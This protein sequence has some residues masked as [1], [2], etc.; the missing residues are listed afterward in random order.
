VKALRFIDLQE[1]LACLSLSINAEFYPD[2]GLG[3]F[4]VSSLQ[5]IIRPL[6]DANSECFK[7][8]PELPHPEMYAVYFESLEAAF[9]PAGAERFTIWLEDIWQNRQRLQWDK[10]EIALA[11]WRGQLLHHSRDLLGLGPLS[12]PL[13]ERL[14]WTHADDVE[15]KIA[16]LEQRAPENVWDRK[17]YRVRRFLQ[18]PEIVDS[19]NNIADLEIAHHPFRPVLRACQNYRFEIFWENFKRLAPADVKTRLHGLVVAEWSESIAP[20]SIAPDDLSSR[21]AAALSKWSF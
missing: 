17:M 13:V 7:E 6:I 2:M 8:V 11:T 14:G 9:G 10:Y 1:A 15:E 12:R 18:D 16:K 3:E 5:E 21:R 4:E 19:I 20:E